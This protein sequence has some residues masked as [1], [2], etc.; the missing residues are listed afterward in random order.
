MFEC[1]LFVFNIALNAIKRWKKNI[2]GNFYEVK[3]SMI[4]AEQL[5]EK[6]PS[7]DKKEHV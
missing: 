7:K 1:W 4:K 5:Q 3:T 2:Y 6:D